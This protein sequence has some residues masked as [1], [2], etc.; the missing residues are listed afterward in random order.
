[1]IGVSRITTPKDDEDDRDGFDVGGDACGMD[2]LRLRI[3]E[4][5]YHP[6]GTKR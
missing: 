5:H 2:V 3:T 1:M 4:L 6:I